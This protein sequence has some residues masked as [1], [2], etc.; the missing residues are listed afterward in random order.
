[1]S[2]ADHWTPRSQPLC[3]PHSAKQETTPHTSPIRHPRIRPPNQQLSSRLPNISGSSN[4]R[5]PSPSNAMHGPAP[6]SP[7][8]P[9]SFSPTQRLPYAPMRH[10]STSPGRCSPPQAYT[11]PCRPTPRN[12]TPSPLSARAH[13]R[14][15]T[16]SPA[17]PRSPVPPV[18]LAAGDSPS[19]FS[20]ED[21][22][23][24]LSCPS[25][26]S[27]P[28]EMNRQYTMQQS[29]SPPQCF[30]SSASP[31][32][33]LPCIPPRPSEAFSA[34][35]LLSQTPRCPEDAPDILG[36]CQDS[37]S[38]AAQPARASFV[39]E[40]EY[41]QTP[42]T[43]DSVAGCQD[44]T[45]PAVQPP[46]ASFV[47][48][49]EYSQTPRTPDSV[50]CTPAAA[51][52]APANPPAASIPLHPEPSHTPRTP[53]VAGPHCHTLPPPV[54]HCTV[55]AVAASPIGPSFALSKPPSQM[56]GCLESDRGS[57]PAPSHPQPNPPPTSPSMSN[58]SPAVTPSPAAA[59]FVIEPEP[60]QTPRRPSDSPSPAVVSFIIEPQDPQLSQ[61]YGGTEPETQH[62]HLPNLH[63]PAV[64]ITAQ[65]QDLLQGTHTRAGPSTSTSS[66]SS[67]M[68]SQ[69][70]AGLQS[71]TSSSAI[72]AILH[73]EHSMHDSTDSLPSPRATSNSGAISTTPHALNNHA[74]PGLRLDVPSGDSNAH[75]S[76]PPADSSGHLAPFSLANPRRVSDRYLQQSPLAAPNITQ[77]SSGP[78]HRHVASQHRTKGALKAT[79]HTSPP[80]T[81]DNS[82]D[83]LPPSFAPAGGLDRPSSG[84]LRR[85]TSWEAADGIQQP[86][87]SPF[88][89]ISSPLYD[90]AKSMEPIGGSGK[91]PRSPAT[92]L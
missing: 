61:G 13:H 9:S 83:L 66:G 32:P 17:K 3:G 25:S 90:S 38:P 39:L 34:G 68:A 53:H 50:N 85:R 18:A 33:R 19:G 49:P 62:T 16:P 75:F 14:V 55:P 92:R 70:E 35:P 82:S 76:S 37:S 88:C 73:A 31:V 21:S 43:P 23:D 1:M 4:S 26:L 72:S 41:S 78:V 24:D 52:A 87:P 27:L 28:S 56:S 11:S 81:R 77:P 74:T 7:S 84:Q 63:F 40:P 29:L 64:H 2:R 57:C 58:T 36:R 51:L 86:L 59:S 5:S 12:Y 30:R 47:L 54:P 42:R 60:S 46:R 89:R 8:T 15:I 6:Y 10:D 44:S 71:T 91:I 79:T 67:A 69:Y 45:S 65:D 22:D 48:E 80:S 20:T